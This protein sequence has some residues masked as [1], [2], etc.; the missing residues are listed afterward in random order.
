MIERL[1][2]LHLDGDPTVYP[3]L[4]KEWER[5]GER[6]CGGGK[7]PIIHATI[8]NL[9]EH[10]RTIQAFRQPGVAI[11]S[12]GFSVAV[13]SAPKTR[14]GWWVGGRLMD[15][16]AVFAIA[17]DGS[18]KL[19]RDDGATK[20]GF[21]PTQYTPCAAATIARAPSDMYDRTGL[22]RQSKRGTHNS[23]RQCCPLPIPEATP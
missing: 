9:S 8:D 12:T 3:A 5:R 17:I 21:D 14:G 4:A 16:V 22:C 6:W 10:I 11:Q 15:L 20:R 13:Y 18:A 23:R 1:T 2:R 19:V 7:Q